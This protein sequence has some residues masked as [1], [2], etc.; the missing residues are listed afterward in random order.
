VIQ[1]DMEH[2]HIRHNTQ[3]S[4]DNWISTENEGGFFS[5]RRFGA[6]SA[7]QSQPGLS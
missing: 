6:V 1:V 2:D 7:G 5:L 3:R 4:W